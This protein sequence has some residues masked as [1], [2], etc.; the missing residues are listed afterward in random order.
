MP[1]S[2]TQEIQSLVDNDEVIAITLDTNVYHQFGYNLTYKSLVAPK[3]FVGTN[4]AFLMSDVTR[5]EVEAHIGSEIAAAAE[6]AAAGVNQFLKATRSDVDR[7]TVLRELGCGLDA[8]ARARELFDAYAA[9]TGVEI[10]P[11]DESVSVTELTE[12]YFDGRPPFSTRKDKKSEFPDA[13]ALLSLEAWADA[14][15]GYIIAIS[16]DGDWAAYGEES[17]RLVVVPDLAAGLTLFNTESS[18]VVARIGE[19]L[20]AQKAPA[21]SR[22]IAGG[23]ER[24]IEEFHILANAAYYYDEEAESSR[25]ISWQL[26]DDA[27]FGIM[28]SDTETVTVSFEVDFEA[29]FVANFTLSVRDGIDKDYVTIGGTTVT[30]TETI[31]VPIVATIPKDELEDP[32]PNEVEVEARGLTIDF[33]YVEPDWNEEPD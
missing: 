21:L 22:A 23:L 28:D 30:R 13:I 17:D 24:L 1:K 20:R 26:A 12:L 10:V 32:E 14:K 8:V 29:E 31:S 27:R 19:Q 2:T 4:V 16:K 11:V 18:V 5:R 7:A 9:E 6:K 15:D 33:G 25:L 3:Q